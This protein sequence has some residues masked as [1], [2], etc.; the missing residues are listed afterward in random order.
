MNHLVKKYAD[1]F[2]RRVVFEARLGEFN[3]TPSGHALELTL[4]QSA[5]Q[6]GHPHR[7]NK[8]KHSTEQHFVQQ[9]AH[10]LDVVL[11]LIES[12]ELADLNGDA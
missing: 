12:K 9:I 4:G 11:D 6:T 10:Q 5:F 8:R 3:Q 7:R 1:N 2:Q